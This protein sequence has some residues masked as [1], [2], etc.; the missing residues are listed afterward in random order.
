W[1][2]AW[3]YADGQAE[4]TLFWVQEGRPGMHFSILLRGIEQMMLTGKPSWNV[5]RTLLSS[6]ALHALL[7][8]EKE[9]QR[10]VETPYLNVQYERVW[11]WTEPPPPPP[12]REWREQ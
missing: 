6:G 5:E 4:S 8:S 10:R 2:A 11:R 3:R 12:M 9:D 1:S 7:V